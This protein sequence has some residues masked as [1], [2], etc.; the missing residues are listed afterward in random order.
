MDHS[1]NLIS[2]QIAFVVSLSV[3]PF[4]GHDQSGGSAICRILLVELA[5]GRRKEE[6]TMVQNPY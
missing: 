4:T 2:A 1:I 6:K 3:I 5:E